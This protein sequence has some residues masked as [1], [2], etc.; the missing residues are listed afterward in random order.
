MLA[1]G[2][3]DRERVWGGGGGGRDRERVCGGG[4]GGREGGREGDVSG[5]ALPVG[6]LVDPGTSDRLAFI[7]AVGRGEKR[8]TETDRQ[9]ERQTGR[10]RGSG[11]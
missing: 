4:E 11:K 5:S 9:T 2:G 6:T 10:E 7:L 8:D 3:R 1:A